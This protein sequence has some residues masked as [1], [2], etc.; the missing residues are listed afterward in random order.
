MFRKEYLLTCHF[1]NGWFLKY[2]TWPSVE[3]L[4]S[5]RGCVGLSPLFG[6]PI[7]HPKPIKISL[8]SK[9]VAELKRLLEA[10]G[11]T[12][13]SLMPTYNHVAESICKR[14]N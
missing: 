6:H 12:K 2:G 13:E 1:A 9:H 8:D 4:L 5:D 11:I 10:E 14:L 3:D 7:P